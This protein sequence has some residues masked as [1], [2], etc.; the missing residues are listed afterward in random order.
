M[1]NRRFIVGLIELERKANDFPALFYFGII[2][3]HICN[4][5]QH[6]F[7]R[8]DNLLLECTRCILLVE[9]VRYF[10]FI[11]ELLQ[12]V[13]GPAALVEPLA[14]VIIEFDIILVVI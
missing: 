11:S 8:L 9:I 6:L 12:G 3:A 10:E 13:D 4:L 1:T 14:D 7:C 5:V 2:E